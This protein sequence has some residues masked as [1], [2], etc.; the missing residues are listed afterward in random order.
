MA[1]ANSPVPIDDDQP[2][3]LANSPASPDDPLQEVKLIQIQTET[4]Q[5]IVEDA[6]SDYI[7]CTVE[8]TTR[9]LQPTW[10]LLRLTARVSRGK[11]TVFLLRYR[12]S[13][14]T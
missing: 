1:P 9:S 8:E 11:N 13:L 14:Y 4:C 12:F 10:G 5:C 3:V 2:A 6:V 7:H